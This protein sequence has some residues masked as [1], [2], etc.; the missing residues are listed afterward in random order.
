MD[1]ELRH[2]RVLVEVADAGSISTAAARLR[3]SQP[4]LT[5]QLR[6]IENSLGSAVFER[7]RRGVMPTEY[8]CDVLNRS[9]IVLSEVSQIRG[10]DPRRVPQKGD[11]ISADVGGFP[12]SPLWAFGAR[13]ETLVPAENIRL[14]TQW[15]MQMLL[16]M[17]E[18]A[19]LDCAILRQ[20]PDFEIRLPDNVTGQVMVEVDPAFVALPSGHPLAAQEEIDL[21]DLARET[22]V[23]EPPDDSGMHAHFTR[24]CR[25]AGFAARLEHL[26]IDSL[27]AAQMIENGRAI[28]LTSSSAAEPQGV[29]IRPLRG[30]PIHRRLLLTWRLDSPLAA[31]ADKLLRL[32]IEAYLEIVR[33][34]PAYAVWSRRHPTPLAPP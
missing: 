20:M 32:G 24:A 8:G 30:T 13:L 16:Q 9:R 27:A 11:L 23:G 31:H 15:S 6:R 25:A 17:L 19:R 12:G 3:V 7:S 10:L 2:L 5:A 29:A 28:A 21:A 14:Q 1:L 33:E 34:S 4:A 22:W 18:S 26:T